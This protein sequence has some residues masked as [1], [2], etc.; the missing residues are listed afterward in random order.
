[1]HRGNIE[2]NTQNKGYVNG[3]AHFAITV[4]DRTKVDSMVEVFRNDGYKIVGLP[5]VTGDGYYEAVVLDPEGNVVE[6][7]AES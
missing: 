3:L 6:L 2:A 1:M 5:R 7:V 4:G